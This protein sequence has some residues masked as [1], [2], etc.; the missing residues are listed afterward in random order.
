MSNALY[1]RRRRRLRKTVWNLVGLA[2][3]SSCFPCT[4]M[5]STASSSTTRSSP[6]ADVV[7]P[8]PHA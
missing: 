8:E 7:L 1:G 6:R 4:G 3:S 2:S 5:I